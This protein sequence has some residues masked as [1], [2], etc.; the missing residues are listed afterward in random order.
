MEQHAPVLIAGGSGVVGSRAA[1]FLRRL[2]PSLPL[3][4]GGRDVS[5]AEVVAAAV[6]GP[7]HA[8]AVDLTRADL[9]QA[10]EVAYSAIMVFLRDDTLNSMR[11]AQARGIPYLSL[12]TGTFEIGPEVAHYVHAP[13]AAAVVLASHWLAG[14][15]VMP[16]LQAARDYQVVD[17]IHLG[18]LVDPEDFGGPAAHTDYERIMR[19]SP[20]ALTLSDGAFTWVDSVA[21]GARDVRLD[22]AVEESSTRAAGAPFSTEIVVEIDGTLRTGEAARTRTEIV[23]PQGQAAL[24]GLCAAL[25]VERLLGLDGRAPVPPGLYFPESILDPAYVVERMEEFG[26][27][28][29]R[30]E[31]A[32]LA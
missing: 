18:V 26:A 23:H 13:R 5:R 9:G 1:Q 14:A 24:T 2:H 20:A 28:V 25:A 27:R 30:A 32:V 19:A 17:A 22:V 4:I 29:R 7:A 10:P 12:S 8:V 21:T 16:A 31:P 3:A 6:G 15:A 11:F